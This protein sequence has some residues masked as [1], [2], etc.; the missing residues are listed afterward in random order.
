MTI[1]VW[2]SAVLLVVGILSKIFLIAVRKEPIKTIGGMA[3][4]L[5]GEIVFLAWAIVLLTRGAA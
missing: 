5:V 1:F 2:V 3:L 4:E